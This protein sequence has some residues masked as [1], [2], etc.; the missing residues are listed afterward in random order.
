MGRGRAHT[1]RRHGFTLVEV[2]A[3]LAI[4]AVIIAATSALV[5][6]VALNFDYGTRGV[7]EGERLILAVERL[8]SDIGSA[9]FVTRMSE[10]SAA[11]AFIGEPGTAARPARMIFVSAGGVAASGE[12]VVSLTVEQDEDVAR[13]VRR[14][15]P[16][17][18][19]RTRFED[20]T[21]QDPVVLLE[22]KFLMS[23]AFGRLSE[24]N[25]LAWSDD[26][27]GQVMPRFVQLK[28]RD[29]RT[30]ADL[31]PG[32]EF[33]IRADASAGCAQVGSQGGSQVGSQVGSQAGSQVGSQVGSQGGSAPCFS[34]AAAKSRRTHDD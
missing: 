18:G 20:I 26:W 33:L 32:T 27:R 10:G 22:G 19:P 12:E 21:L 29:R 25:G 15:A 3:A 7:S 28:L 2:L 1:E 17:N 4:A 9:R 14:R 6:N 8:A 34:S 23:F 11:L 30:G 31:L 24:D 16:W 5:H 13:L